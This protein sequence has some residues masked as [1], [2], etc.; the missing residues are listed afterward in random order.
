L[1]DESFIDHPEGIDIGF[2]SVNSDQ[3][4]GKVTEHFLKFRLLH[5]FVG[6]ERW[7]DVGKPVAKQLMGCSR[8]R[9]S[10]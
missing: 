9:A 10:L 2:E 4:A 3:I 6:T 7:H 1:F 8:N 5:R